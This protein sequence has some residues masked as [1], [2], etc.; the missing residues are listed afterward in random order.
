LS[1]HI[2]LRFPNI[3]S[4]LDVDDYKKIDEKKLEDLKGK[5]STILKRYLKNIKTPIIANLPYYVRSIYFTDEE[6]KNYVSDSDIDTN[7]NDCIDIEYLSHINKND[8]KN[9]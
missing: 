6:L 2:K 4:D 9:I 7:T 1:Q 5:K 8:Y 3:P